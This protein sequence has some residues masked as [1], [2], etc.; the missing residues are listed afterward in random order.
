MRCQIGSD[1]LPV[2]TLQVD[3]K[4]FPPDEFEGRLE[5]T[6]GGHNGH[7]VAG[8]FQCEARQVQTNAEVDPLLL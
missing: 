5:V 3:A 2:E 7:S 4:A 1:V 8:L 6:V